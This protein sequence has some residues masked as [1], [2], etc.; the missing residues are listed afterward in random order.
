MNR[1]SIAAA[2]AAVL[3]ASTANACLRCHSIPDFCAIATSTASGSGA[4]SE[5]AVTG[6]DSVVVV[7]VGVTVTVPARTVVT[8][9]SLG[10]HGRLVVEG[11]LRFVN[12]LIYE[13]GEE[14]W[15]DGA[16]EVIRDVVPTDELQWG[17]GHITSGKTT[18]SG[19][20]RA[21]MARAIGD[22]ALGQT[23]IPVEDA[24]TWRTG[25][26]V[27]I[28]D[29][30]QQHRFAVNP[31]QHERRTIA[32]VGSASITLDAPLAWNHPAPRHTDGSLWAR[33]P[34]FNLTRGIY[35]TSENPEGARGHWAAVGR[36]DVRLVGVEFS[37]LGRTETSITGQM[38]QTKK[39]KNQVGRYGGPHL[40]HVYG[41]ESSH[42][43]YQWEIRSCVV[44]DVNRNGWGY[45]VHQTHYGLMQDCLFWGGLRGQTE[46][47][48]AGII[49][50]DG[51]EFHNVF[52]NCW[53]G[54]AVSAFWM[55]G[56][57]QTIRQC[58]AVASRF[59]FELGRDGKA[60]PVWKYPAERGESPETYESRPEK[61]FVPVDFSHNE[62]VACSMVAINWGHLP[63][64]QVR[65]ADAPLLLVHGPMTAWHCV[66]G[67]NGYYDD[68]GVKLVGWRLQSDATQKDT[69]DHYGVAFG[70]NSCARF[71]C[72]DGE[73]IGQ[74]SGV[75]YRPRGGGSRMVLRRMRISTKEG[76]TG[77][78]MQQSPLFGDVELLIDGCTFL[79][80][81]PNEQH[82][83][84][85][86]GYPTPEGVHVRPLSGSRVLVRDYGGNP[87]DDFDCYWVCQAPDVKL[88]PA[89][90][91]PSHLVGLTNQQ[92][93]DQFGQC[94]LGVIAPNTG[95]P[96]INGFVSSPAIQDP[97]RHGRQEAFPVGDAK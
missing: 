22:L 28:P 9:H 21:P 86:L 44:R 6:P 39:T 41:P 53:S 35:V 62:A 46:V 30:R 38:E 80:R 65:T 95:R 55:V 48:G 66:S 49:T 13:D 11:E 14:Q 67:Y 78:L 81:K 36:A 47:A 93:F 84:I 15:L 24:S 58:G 59:A 74:F 97:L 73:F 85:D 72:E 33:I 23:A 52:Q 16:R 45:T 8:V 87:A 56:P 83:D 91:V 90:G 7:P 69:K 96:G 31:V 10:V 20:T 18:Y 5:V 64:A 63:A 57:E 27:L 34:I 12:L 1:L 26:T 68:F 76:I 50:E 79:S 71:E 17:T 3:V 94:L 37:G 60:K 54:N 51:P 2:V 43:E 61:Q 42:N 88:L 77:S 89:V 70:G 82:W 92:A 4:L 40:H 32:A 25:D 19:S 75:H 29:V